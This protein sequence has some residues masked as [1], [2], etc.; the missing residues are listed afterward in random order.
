MGTTSL[1]SYKEKMKYKEVVSESLIRGSLD[2][3]GH[4]QNLPLL[5]KLKRHLA[6]L[7]ML[8]VRFSLPQSPPPFYG[9]LSVWLTSQ[10]TWRFGCIYK[11]EVVLAQVGGRGGSPGCTELLSFESRVPEGFAF[12][13]LQIPELQAIRCGAA[14]GS[15]EM[16][17]W[18]K[19]EC[20]FF[21]FF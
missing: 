5:W 11:Q 18:N 6:N 19:N 2:K 4:C 13:H 3:H 8:L 15:Q 21:M 16:Q 10:A 20:L 9:A 14:E 7:E 17:D 12:R 1:L